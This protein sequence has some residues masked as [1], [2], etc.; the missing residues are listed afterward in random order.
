MA[1]IEKRNYIQGDT[2]AILNQ[3]I[4]QF[5][6]NTE[7]YIKLDGY[8]KFLFANPIIKLKSTSAVLTLNTDYT[9]VTDTRYTAKEAETG[10]TGF[11]VYAQIKIINATYA[12]VD[13]TF[14]GDNFGTY[15]DNEA[16][17]TL[18][19]EEPIAA[20]DISSANGSIDLTQFELGGANELPAGSTVKGSWFGG[21]ATYYC[22]PV[23]GGKF[24]NDFIPAGL[25]PGDGSTTFAWNGYGNGGLRLRLR[26]NKLD[27]DVLTEGCF[28]KGVA[29]S[30]TFQQFTSKDLHQRLPFTSDGTVQT[31]THEI[32]FINNTYKISG[33]ARTSNT[34]VSHVVKF[35]N[36][37]LSAVDCLVATGST[38][39]ASVNADL[40]IEGE[41]RE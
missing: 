36:K 4:G 35:D 11:T 20:V 5:V 33:N 3:D 15:T 9:L 22:K 29:N 19:G 41:W 38:V 28:D 23:S 16:V 40:K 13:L 8:F 1:T 39:S 21:D 10:G 2:E 17:W 34:G 14:S 12:G 25:A 6:I 27:W 31:L 18:A 24:Y 37:T 30:T 26:E 32:P 7:S